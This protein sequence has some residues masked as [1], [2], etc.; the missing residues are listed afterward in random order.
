MLTVAALVLTMAVLGYASLLD[1]RT[2]RVRNQVWI[3]LSAAGLAFMVAR[4]LI[5]EKPFEYLL[6]SLPI[7]AILADVYL[8]PD[9][10]GLVARSH[11]AL[12][13]GAAIAMTLAMAFTWHDSEYFVHMLAV[14][15]L[16]ILIVIMYAFDIIRGGADAKALMA[17]AIM[18]PFHPEIWQLPL[19]TPEHWFTGVMFPFTLVVLINAAIVVAVLPAAFLL[20]NLPARDFRFPQS[21]LGYRMNVDD[22]RGRFVWLM[23]R[24]VD[25]RRIVYSKPKRNEDLIAE[26]DKL[27]EMGIDRVWVT[28]KVPF[29]VPMF[30]SVILTTI[31]GNLLLLIIET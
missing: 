12:K 22:A 6:I 28:P 17:L 16:M 4:I 8:D 30:F 18:F 24:I 19:L 11:P 26:L 13:Y 3:L 1:W 10:G 9:K 29:I 31:V 23:E 21:F 15:V 27:S 7:L 14:P 5:D 25:G 20:R 2:R